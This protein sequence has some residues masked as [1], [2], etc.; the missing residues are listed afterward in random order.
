MA[1]SLGCVIIDDSLFI[2]EAVSNMIKEAG[3][4]VIA[5]FGDGQ[6]FLDKAQFLN[7]DV[8]FLDII[9]PNITGLELLEIV[10]DTLPHIKVIMLSG[11]A[12]TDAI[13][14]ALRLGAIDFIQ[15]PVLLERLTILLQKISDNIQTPTVEEISTIGVA[16]TLLT[17]FFDELTAHASSTLRHIIQQQTSTILEDMQRTTKGML[18]IDTYD[19]TIKLDPGLWG[20]HTEDEVI[21]ALK[22]IT[23]DLQFELQFIY[24]D[25]FIINLFQNA[26]GTVSSK[27]HLAYLFE[28]VSPEMIGLPALPVRSDDVK[29]TVGR[30]ASTYQEY[31]DSISLA[32]LHVDDHGPNVIMKLNDHL[33]SEVEYMR[34]SIFFFTLVGQGE[35][36]QEGLFGP[37][38]VTSE[39]LLSSLVY[40]TKIDNK[41]VLFCIYF[42]DIAERIVSDYNRISFLIKTR[43]TALK[44]IKDLTNAVL[45]RIMEDIIHYLLEG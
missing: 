24:S 37:L 29:T 26:I 4:Q 7:T 13:S 6:E 27:R 25:E 2:R 36:F 30:A 5:S 39:N 41:L 31:Y 1:H 3:H 20:L 22:Q 9:L 23:V 43:I 8:L 11:I 14:A 32:V 17:E 44:N 18:I 35:N 33:L 10:S 42:T 12:Q 15:K 34:N 21:N 45:K 19:R 38:P 16:T 40:A 28:Q